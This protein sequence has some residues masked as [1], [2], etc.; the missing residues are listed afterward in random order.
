M[1]MQGGGEGADPGV[2]GLGPP[3][4]GCWVGSVG[5]VSAMITG[6][7]GEWGGISYIVYPPE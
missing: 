5:V 2:G 1:G 6:G 4:E 7:G 3:G